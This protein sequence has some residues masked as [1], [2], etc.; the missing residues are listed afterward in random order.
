MTVRHA[1]AGR[2]F[3][4]SL[5]LAA[6]AACGG[7]GG[8]GG[9]GGGDPPPPPAL[10]ISSTALA[11]GV[12][13]VPYNQTVRV[14]GGTGARTF[15]VADG[16]LPDGLSLDASNGVIAGTPA[17]VAGTADFT[18]EVEDSGSP[19]QTDSQALS[20]TINATALGRNDT[21][22]TATA[23]GNGTFTAS[24]SPSGDP[25]TVLAPDEDYYQI[26]TTAATTVTV[27]ID[28]QVN[29]S[30]LDSVI[31]IVD[32]TG[33]RLNTCV[34]PDFNTECVHDDE[35]LGQDLDSSIEVRVGG[36][37]VFFVHVV[38]FGSGARPDKT[39]DI[40][41]SGVN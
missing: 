22:A 25:N 12:L 26:T 10:T 4:A 32:E 17:G 1:A 11:T 27:D 40:T 34:A 2:R 29:G 39:Y 41:I 37:T 24:I 30:P 35:V 13:G 28:A 16:S 19:A 31:E 15:T 36:A 21:I 18:V 14:T 7:G 23:L 20:I 38:D 8:D 33:D 5:A 9:G 3:A 6:L